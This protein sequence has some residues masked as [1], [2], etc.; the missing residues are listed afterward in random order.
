VL[1]VIT[2]KIA[3]DH[4]RQSFDFAFF[5]ALNFLSHSIIRNHFSEQ[6]NFSAISLEL[7]K[8]F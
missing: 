4:K 3:R 7:A 1:V 8:L 2:T 6:G 5:I